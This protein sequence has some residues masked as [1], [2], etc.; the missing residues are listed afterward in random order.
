MIVF[1]SNH[2]T[3]IGKRGERITVTSYTTD[4][5]NEYPAMKI[6]EIVVEA[7]ASIS[8]QALKLLAR[9]G[10]PV[11][12]I[13][14]HRPYGIFHPYVSHGTILTRKEQLI[15]YHDQRGTKAA[16]SFA[17]AAI[18]NKAFLLRSLARN[19][20]DTQPELSQ[21][22]EKSYGTIMELAGRVENYKGHVDMIRNALMGI[23]GKATDY[24]FEQLK[25]LIPDE[26]RFNDR[27][28]RP[29]QDPVNSLLSYGYSVLNTRVLCYVILA[30]LDP[31]G[32][33]LH[34]DR[35]GKPSL[36]LDII[37][38][39]RQPI[40]DRTVLKIITR[41]M[42]D[43][44]KDFEKKNGMCFMSQHAK[45]VLLEALFERFE[46]TI[47]Y[48]DKNMKFENVIFK[49]TRQLSAFFM[50]RISEYTPFIPGW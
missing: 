31:F 36:T 17:K 21:S 7:N 37:E 22:L 3:K 40:V 43:P 46:T 38:E 4:E 15:A 19:R 24:Y 44:E 16:I 34:A 29:P 26:F 35:S 1:V 6:A 14:N 11:L 47:R 50:H 25:E 42:I 28:R 32:G 48:Q 30:G 13:G 5:K 45:T 39:F 20:K 49:Q 2:G 41:R 18:H 33:F 8:T 12:F 10:V 9:H 27:N 23:E